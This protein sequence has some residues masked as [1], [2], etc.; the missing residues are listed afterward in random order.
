MTILNDEQQEQYQ[1]WLTLQNVETVDTDTVRTLVIEGLD[2]AKSLTSTEYTLWRTWLQVNDEFDVKNRE[3]LRR[4]Q[5]VKKKIFIPS[6]PED[7]EAIEP[8]LV[9]VQQHFPV[10]RV[11]IWGTERIAFVTNP[12]P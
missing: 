8:E 1:D 5:S 4:I 9:F 11:S 2:F 6:C 3:T 7:I 10:P 12:D